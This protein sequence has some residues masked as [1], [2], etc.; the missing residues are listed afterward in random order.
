MSEHE[1]QGHMSAEAIKRYLATLSLTQALWWFIENT[2]RGSVG[3]A[4]IFFYLRERVRT[5]GVS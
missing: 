3:S 5:E 2:P 4:D 1:N